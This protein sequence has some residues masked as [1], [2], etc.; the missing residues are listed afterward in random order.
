M[1]GEHSIPWNF[2]GEVLTTTG[3]GVH[4]RKFRSHSTGEGII[5]AYNA[6]A[7]GL[8][9]WVHCGPIIVGERRL[10][11]TVGLDTV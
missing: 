1:I 9:K 8:G 5:P 3:G 4:R 7:V 6:G 11:I 2:V 10:P